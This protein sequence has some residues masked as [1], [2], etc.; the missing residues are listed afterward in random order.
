ML[1]RRKCR[2]DWMQERRN[3]GRVGK[4]GCWK[5]KMQERRDAGKENCRKEGIQEKI[6][7]GQ[8]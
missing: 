1:E 3:A 5:G 8:K 7:E 4:V 2:K 6:N